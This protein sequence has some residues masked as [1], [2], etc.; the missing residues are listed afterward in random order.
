MTKQPGL[1]KMMGIIA[2]LA[3]VI[4]VLFL[5]VYVVD[6]LTRSNAFFNETAERSALVHIEKTRQKAEEQA[7]VHY[8]NLYEI[9]DKLE[10]ADSHTAVVD[11]M[12]SYIGSEQFGNLRFYSRG[13]S[14]TPEGNVVEA[15]PGG[16]VFIRALSAANAQGCT[17]V[18]RDAFSG[19]DCIA[20][21]VP[22]RGS[23]V[24]DGVLSIVPARNIIQLQDVL[25][26][27]LEA[28]L[29]IDE[30]GQVLSSGRQESFAQSPGND[31][32]AFVSSLSTK[33][34][35]V[36]TV[37]AAVRGQQVAACSLKSAQGEYTM[38]MT[39]LVSFDNHFILV[40]LSDREVLITA[41]SVYIRQIITL[42][43]IAIIAIATGLGYALFYYRKM[44]S[45]LT[46]ANYTDPIVGCPNSEQFR[47]VAAR[48]L[49]ERQ[50]P[51]AMAVFDIRQFR[52]MSEKLS[53]TD[54]AELLKFVAKMLETFCAPGE[55]Y[56]YLG[57]GRFA[58]LILYEHDRAVRDRVRLV[59]AMANKHAVLG[60]SKSKK[61]FNVGVA[62]TADSGRRS[63][64]E[65]LDHAIAA[66]VRAQNNVNVPYELF[67]EKVNAERD[68][69]DR[70]ESEMESALA[71][72]EFRLF[73]QPKYNVIGD[74]VDS[75]EA[76]VRWFDPKTGD[77]RF[78]GEF[79][80]LFETNGFIT[81]LDHFMYIEA[82]KC[83]SAAAERGE[84]V[85]PISV[86]VSLVTVNNGDFLDFYIDNKK[87]YRVADGFITIEFTE[88]FAM[89][90]YQ[91]I[92]S[93]VNRL[94]ENGIRCAL[95]D[96]GSGYASL[97]VLKNIPIDELKLDRLFLKP[98]FS[99]EQD[100]T[101][102]K[103]MIALA[104]SL[105]MQ[106]VQEGVETKEMFDRV[107]AMGCDVIQG[108]YYAK[109]IPL[110]EYRLFINSN[111]S[112]KFKSL[113]K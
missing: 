41:E 111:T 73:L 29:L 48:T 98:G 68:H 71:N 22:V 84:K 31:F 65:L 40:T 82:L 95:D 5:V 14:H 43:V 52:Y 24:V 66:C 10:N 46:A 54:M 50:V 11:V 49:Q 97:G 20:F 87:K 53:E 100:A 106:V 107:I 105:N 77:Y 112:I 67:T 51:Y 35:A 94:H 103:A 60:K 76:L 69:N 23:A 81:K 78:P 92:Y 18:F 37:G 21:F 64:P 7:Q 57:E 91:E 59:E 113:V 90:D 8:N 3:L 61:K 88:S 99:R 33:K 16:D 36:N 42:I 17:P 83:L 47:V 44:R 85:V 32:Y 45:A 9:A 39:P 62:L 27:Q 4:A 30:E 28:V 63:V 93:I 34:T 56:G 108:Y 15:E 80:G 86:N 25:D 12:R 102:L 104:K 96:F 13:V 55:T 2:R 110:E 89:G 26:P 101:V 38:A 58:I 109:A 6:L 75:A 79:I 72:G 1:R 70:I 19:Y 74:R